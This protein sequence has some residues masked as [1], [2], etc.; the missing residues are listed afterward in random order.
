M[1]ESGRESGSLLGLI[2]PLELP[3]GFTS[4]FRP[5]PVQECFNMSRASGVQIMDIS[6]P[7]EKLF[8]FKRRGKKKGRKNEGEREKK[9]SLNGI[10]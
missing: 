8:F 2:F 7:F 9:E 5:R 6:L 4:S 1:S 3:K 10:T